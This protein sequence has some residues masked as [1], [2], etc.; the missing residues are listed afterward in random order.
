MERLFFTAAG[1]LLVWNFGKLVELENGCALLNLNIV[2]EECFILFVLIYFIGSMS[3]TE[4]RR[5]TL[6][7]L[8]VLLFV[9]TCGAIARHN[10]DKVGG[11]R[12]ET[13]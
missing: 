13:A 1:T 3:Q 2:K 6:K 12:S 5:K 10:R 4:Y 7:W 8:K 9:F 11:P